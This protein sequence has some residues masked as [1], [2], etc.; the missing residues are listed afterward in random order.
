MATYRG[1][2]QKLSNILYGLPDNKVYELKEYKEQ[3]NKEQNAKYWKLINELSLVLKIG[4]EELHFQMLK[5]YSVRY[6][7]LVPE[8]EQI[9]GIQYFERKSTIQARDGKRFDI[10]HVFTP[11]HE[12]RTDEFAILMK[13]L[14]EDCR[15]QGIDTRSP[16]EIARDEQIENY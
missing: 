5:N 15:E 4:V 11:S 7:I 10:Y 3:R 14:I 8:N 16:E 9:R 1:S 12:L 2:K 6:E 13:G